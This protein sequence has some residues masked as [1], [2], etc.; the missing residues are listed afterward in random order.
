MVSAIKAAPYRC[1]WLCR[2]LQATAMLL[3]SGPLF[4]RVVGLTPFD[5]TST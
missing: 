4:I 5:R 3:W 2:A 1:L